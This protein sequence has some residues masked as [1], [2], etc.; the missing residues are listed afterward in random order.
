MYELILLASTAA[1]AAG[2]V[3]TV[4]TLV[5]AAADNKKSLVYDA[6]NAEV[7]TAVRQ[8]MSA[9]LFLPGSAYILA[10]FT[11]VGTSFIL[12]EDLGTQTWGWRVLTLGV[13]LL[14]VI[15][16][17]AIRQTEKAKDSISVIQNWPV[18]LSE[19]KRGQ[20]NPTVV[21][22]DWLTSM[23][24]R[25]NSLD[26]SVSRSDK[27]DRTALALLAPTATARVDW[28]QAP[29]A[30]VGIYRS[31]NNG[32]RVKV[33]PTFVVRWLAAS[34]EL[35]FTTLAWVVGVVGYWFLS[36]RGWG[37]GSATYLAY[38]STALLLLAVP[39]IW[40]AARARLIFSARRAMRNQAYRDE[41]EQILMHV[42]RSMEAASQA[43]TRE[44]QQPVWLARAIS[45]IRRALSSSAS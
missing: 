32:D 33:G 2:V 1:L 15:A 22:A 8:T 31:I 13:F 16:F 3:G 28:M 19:A 20:R 29:Y 44:V 7:L 5:G 17:A 10:I 18:M 4:V 24:E 45:D 26:R 35:T 39:L 6:P 11:N 14:A 38:G 9:W 30:G 27:K 43:P 40:A 21:R 12:D 25:F 37:D 36:V 41:V 42:R 34:L 23:Q